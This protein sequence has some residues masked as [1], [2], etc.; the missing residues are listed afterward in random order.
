MNEPYHGSIM[1]QALKKGDNNIILYKMKMMKN[2]PLVEG[3]LNV[4]PNNKHQFRQDGFGCS[5]LSPM[6]LGPVIHNQPGLPDTKNIENYHQ[7]NKVY[8]NEIDDD[9]NPTKEFRKRQIEG[10]NDIIPHRHKFDAET[11]KKLRKEING[12]NKNA[13]LY[14]VHKTLD[15]VERKFTYVQ[16]RYFYS[17]AYEKLSKNTNDFDKLKEMI[18]NGTNLQIC[19]YDAYEITDDIYNHYCDPKNAFGHEL[20]LYCLLTIENSDD[21]PWNVYRKNN[22][23]IYKNI[24]C[25]I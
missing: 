8:P 19:G 20:V 6:Q 25:V 13:P 9:G 5:S 1:C 24:A 4:F 14:S 17:K 11:M 12:E 3:Y 18:K 22:K 15:G 16:S 21:Y 23:K 10:Y 2:V 7:Y